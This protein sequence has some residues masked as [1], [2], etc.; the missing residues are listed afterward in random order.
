MDSLQLLLI[1]FAER[2]SFIG[3]KG[4][5]M[6]VFHLRLRWLTPRSWSLED[7]VAGVQ[8]ARPEVAQQHPPGSSGTVPLSISMHRQRCTEWCSKYVNCPQSERKAFGIC[9]LH[10][11]S[12]E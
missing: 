6:E 3:N 9:N 11:P 2:F 5:L 12:F 1:G 7:L 4:V 8:M 10:L